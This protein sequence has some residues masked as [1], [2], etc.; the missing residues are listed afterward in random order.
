[1]KQRA[2]DGSDLWK[3]EKNVEHLE[4][5]LV[6]L[7]ARSCSCNGTAPPAGA[8]GTLQKEV[9]WLKR[10]LEEHLRL[11]KNVFSNADELAASGD[12]LELDRLWELTKRREKRKRGRGGGERSRREA[13]GESETSSRP[14]ETESSHLS[15]SLSSTGDSFPSSQSD[16]SLL[17]VGVS[18]RSASDGTVTFGP[19]QN[20][21]FTAPQDGLYLFVLTLDLR[22]GP[23]HIVLRAVEE[24]GG[25]LATLQQQQVEEAGPVSGVGLLLLREGQQVRLEVRGEWAESESNVLAVLLL[26]PTT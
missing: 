9:T 17:F 21:V 14:A 11:F 8:D 2:G 3:L 19:H 22:P 16:V 6:G 25:A 13:P 4:R 1:M 5:R 18:P 24:G 7:E 10:G 20:P 15:A 12:T 23:A 26:Q